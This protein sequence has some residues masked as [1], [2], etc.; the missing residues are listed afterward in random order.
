MKNV[1]KKII[2]TI[3]SLDFIF[4]IFNKILNYGWM[5]KFQ[6]E[7]IDRD[8]LEIP[9][10]KKIN[11]IFKKP[12]VL[13]GPFKG[14]KYPG[15]R[16]KSSSL[17]SKLIGS[18]ELEISDFILTAI[19]DKYEQVIDIGCAE[20]YYAVGLALKIEKT[21]VYAYDIDSE[22]RKLTVEMANINNVSKKVVVRKSIKSS[23]FSEFDL[24]K[25]TLIVCD[26]EGAERLIFNSSN[27]KLLKNC[28]LIIETHD[29]V[30]INISTDLEHLFSPTHNVKAIQSIGDNIKAKNYS[31]TELE[32]LDL[33]T[34]YRIFEEGR[35]YVDEW[36]IISPK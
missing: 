11:L 8:K 12:L 16:S 13:N 30:D 23:S 26:I 18:Y 24:T 21:I 27:I 33:L 2:I 3:V 10:K 17:Y 5:I 7:L 28:F 14:M 25:K 4:K 35:R 31:F 1:L 9:Q 36:L 19:D 20:G 29:W 15:F 22:A 32:N 6:R 34:K